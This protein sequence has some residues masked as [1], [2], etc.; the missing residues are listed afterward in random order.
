[1]NTPGSLGSLVPF[2]LAVL[3]KI[4]KC[5]VTNALIP[6]AP[7]T[8]K[9]SSLGGVGPPAKNGGGREVPNKPL[10]CASREMDQYSPEA[11][12][13]PVLELITPDGCASL[14]D[15]SRLLIVESVRRAV[16]GGVSLVQFRDYKSDAAKKAGLAPQLRAATGGRAWFVVNGEP[17]IAR[18]YGADGVHLP[19][20]MMS[21]LVG[22][23]DAGE[24]PRVVG[25]SVHSVAAAI[26][27]A[28]LGA[29][30][31]QVRC[32]IYFQYYCITKDNGLGNGCFVRLGG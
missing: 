29:D 17:D 32:H 20:R 26:K 9:R 5:P 14:E 28:R 2:I 24:W 3:L 23:R 8:P 27:A 1:M 13:P 12:C 19:E 6:A 22:L 18:A 30:Y 31:I 7:A 11:L 25:C 16:A 21:R 4:C 15:P 10:G